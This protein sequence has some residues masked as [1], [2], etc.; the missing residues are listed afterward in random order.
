MWK[1][2]F[3][4]D[5]LAEKGSAHINSLCKWGPATFIYRK[6]ILPSGKP[7]E[8]KKILI[9]SDPTW[10]DEL[11]HYKNLIQKKKLTNFSNDIWIQKQI[12]KSIKNKLV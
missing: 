10:V 5:I 6:R 8:K 11:I 1:N 3:T 12:Y 9:K 2:H 4:C 7:E